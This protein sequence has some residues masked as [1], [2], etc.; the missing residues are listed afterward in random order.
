MCLISSDLKLCTCSTKNV[1]RLKHYWILYRYEGQ[2]LID[3]I[4]LCL[5]PVS[6]SDKN[7]FI[8]EMVLTKRLNEKDVFDKPM[9]FMENDC[10]EIVFNN[11]AEFG[12]SLIYNFKYVGDK[13][14]YR[15]V[16]PFELNE[17]ISIKEGKLKIVFKS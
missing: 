17:Y 15:D 14:E 4:G 9:K 8:N 2:K 3:F 5:P 6:L 1:E 13:W 16:S 11:N 12:E 10:L 7:F